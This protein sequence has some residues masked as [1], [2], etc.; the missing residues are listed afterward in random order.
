MAIGRPTK[1]SD[2]FAKLAYNY[3]LLGATDDNIAEFLGIAVSTLN[4][5][6]EKHPSFME[7]IKKGKLEADARVASSLYHR[8][9]GYSHRETK[10]ATYEGQITD[11]LDV[12]KHYPPDPT[13]MIFWLKNRQPKL[14]RD[15]QELDHQSSDGSMT[16]P[17]VTYNVVDG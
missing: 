13:S 8:A 7:S 5:W 6:K 3:C 15:K 1:Y 9:N 10:I 16:P 12:E 14:W 2:E 4:L 11:T 17:Q